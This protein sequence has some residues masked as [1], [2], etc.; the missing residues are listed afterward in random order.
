LLQKNPIFAVGIAFLGIYF[1]S[2][3]AFAQRDQGTDEKETWIEESAKK[4]Q[5]SKAE[6]HNEP[7]R[8][9]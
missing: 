3:I 2:M 8:K 4:K 5:K 1:L 6:T 7:E 9:P